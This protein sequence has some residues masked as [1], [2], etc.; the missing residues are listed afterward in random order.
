M[1]WLLLVLFVS[2]LSESADVVVQVPIATEQ[3]CEQAA[4]KLR[5]SIRPPMFKETTP[6]CLQISE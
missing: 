1:K 5:Q 4:E 6:I 3:L 2:P